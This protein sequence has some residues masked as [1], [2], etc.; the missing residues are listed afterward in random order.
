MT[1]LI[2]TIFTV[3]IGLTINYKLTNHAKDDYVLVQDLDALIYEDYGNLFHIT[4]LTRFQEILDYSKKTLNTYDNESIHETDFSHIQIL[5]KELKLENNNKNP[6]NKRAIEFIGT[7]WKWISGS[8]DYND[9]II[10]EEKLNDLIKNNNNQYIINSQLLK[11]LA[12]S[13]TTVLS[14]VIYRQN[15]ILTIELTNLINT[16]TLSKIGVLN[17]NILNIKE[18]NEIIKH[19]DV[20]FSISDLIDTS[21]FKILQN[22]ELIIILVKYPIIKQKCNYFKTLAISGNDGKLILPNN[23]VKCTYFLNTE[24]CKLEL[25]NYYCKISHKSNCLTNILNNI[26]TNCS[27]I[28]ERNNDLE[29]ITEGA[30]LLTGK[31]LINNETINGINLLTFEDKINIDGIN[32]TNPTEEIR[33]FMKGYLTEDTLIENY[34][35]S[36]NKEL[37]IHN[38]NLINSIQIDYEEHPIRNTLILILTLL[39]IYMIIKLW[40]I[41]RQTRKNIYTNE[42]YLED[43]EKITNQA[44]PNRLQN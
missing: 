11:L 18:I 34:V 38:I 6:R 15:R 9:K 14:D 36:A 32:Y 23:I 37:S 27:K 28:K 13:K 26:K 30:Y 1:L 19:E 2:T 20:N 16:I 44:T 12:K 41:Y 35:E 5:L 17:P 39:S 29:I 42:M 8:P 22:N 10:I 21:T 33:K 25:N 24:K 43:L 7:A 3:L 40:I 4:N 31:H